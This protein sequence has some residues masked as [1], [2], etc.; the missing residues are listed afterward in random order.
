MISEDYING[1]LTFTLDSYKTIAYKLYD[2][3]DGVHFELYRENHKWAKTSNRMS[4][5]V[6]QVTLGIWMN[7]SEFLSEHSQSHRIENHVVSLDPY[8][9]TPDFETRPDFS[10]SK[11]SIFFGWDAR[12]CSFNNEINSERSSCS[13][14]S[15]ISSINWNWPSI[16][17]LTRDR[18]K[19]RE[20]SRWSQVQ[21]IW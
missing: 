17:V 21:A 3:I 10:S 8:C 19:C 4:M 7:F 14:S 15:L 1:F 6:L 20:G 18:R 2:I 11:T 12:L 16:F 13:V 5:I 9:E